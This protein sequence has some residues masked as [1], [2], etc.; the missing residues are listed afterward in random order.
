MEGGEN[1]LYKPSRPVIS[2]LYSP[3]IVPLSGFLPLALF[4]EMAVVS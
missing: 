2:T 4:P 1:S 3:Y